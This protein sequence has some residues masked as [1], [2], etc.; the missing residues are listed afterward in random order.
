MQVGKLNYCL[1]Q[2]TLIQGQ[3]AVIL[4]RSWKEK[5]RR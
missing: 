3:A 2:Q 5:Y 1:E 4:S